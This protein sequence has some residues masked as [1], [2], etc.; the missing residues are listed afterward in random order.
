M[1]DREGITSWMRTAAMGTEFALTIILFTLGGLVLDR[2]L[3]R[4]VPVWT[5][6]GLAIGMAGGLYRLLR[7]VRQMRRQAPGDQARRR[8]G[9][10]HGKP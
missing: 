10:A 9:G 5:L 3:G 2:R 4:R 1:D 7:Q 6:A 8:D